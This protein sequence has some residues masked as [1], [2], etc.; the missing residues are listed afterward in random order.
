M[1]DIKLYFKNEES[2][3]CYSLEDYLN[4]AKES[5]LNEIELIEAIPAPNEE[6]IW[7]TYHGETVERL[8]CKKSECQLYHSKSGRGVCWHR[9]S[10]FLHGEKVLFKVSE[11]D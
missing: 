3:F 5:G 11:K 4:E 2:G 10:Y 8:I 7:C 6:H 1:R 9:G